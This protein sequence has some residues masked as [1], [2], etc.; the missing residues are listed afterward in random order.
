MTTDRMIAA[1]HDDR[2][3]RE[4]LRNAYRHFG[5]RFDQECEAI[6]AEIDE[7]R[8]RQALEDKFRKLST[9]E[10]EKLLK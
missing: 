10:M 3:H 6:K 1:E 4:F 9:E 7:E 2:Q 5:K 8:R